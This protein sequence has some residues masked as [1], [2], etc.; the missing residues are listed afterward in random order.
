MNEESSGEIQ[1]TN[2]KED[3]QKSVKSSK[4]FEKEAFG[5]SLE[6][7]KQKKKEEAFTPE[8]AIPS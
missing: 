7:E 8:L 1:E 4:H 5:E 3:N 6:M 2:R